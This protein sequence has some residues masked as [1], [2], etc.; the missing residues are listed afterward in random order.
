MLLYHGCQCYS[1]PLFGKS[2][3][4]PALPTKTTLRMKS[5]SFKVGRNFI[6]RCYVY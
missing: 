4:Y 1:M 3:G 2:V 5:A 6:Q